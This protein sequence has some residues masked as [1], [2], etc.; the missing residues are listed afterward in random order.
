MVSGRGQE[1]AFWDTGRVILVLD[2]GDG[3]T[4]KI[5]QVVHLRST[6]FFQVCYTSFKNIF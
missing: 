4:V 3:Y 5:L 1:E 2:L 6:H